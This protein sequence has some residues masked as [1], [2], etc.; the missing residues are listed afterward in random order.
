MTNPISLNEE[1]HRADVKKGVAATRGTM[2][3]RLISSSWQPLPEI[4]WTLAARDHRAVLLE[5]ARQDSSS[6]TSLLF[7]DLLGKLVAWTRQDLDELLSQIDGY[8]AEGRFVAGFFN[9]E[10]G[11]HFLEL[12]P[13]EPESLVER[14]RAVR[15][16]GETLPFVLSMNVIPARV[17][18][19]DAPRR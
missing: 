5:T 18:F 14:T 16:Y 19:R 3:D 6:D 7:L 8:S 17:Q 9:Y 4:F 2:S 13:R 11:E 15:A 10:C 1:I 12:P